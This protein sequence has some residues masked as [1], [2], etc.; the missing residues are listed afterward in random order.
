MDMMV[1]LCSEHGLDEIL[2][3]TKNH[4]ESLGG[5]GGAGERF[6]LDTLDNRLQ[7]LT[8]KDCL[9]GA[10]IDARGSVVGHGVCR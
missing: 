3:I 10:L 5:G 7:L 9:K 6:D 4:S 1:G 8:I 2:N